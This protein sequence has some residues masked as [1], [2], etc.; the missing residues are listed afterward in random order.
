MTAGFDKPCF[1]F[2][3]IWMHSRSS[4]SESANMQ[5]Y[6]GPRPLAVRTCSASGTKFHDANANGRRDAGEPGLPRWMIW[7]DYDDNGVRDANEP[8]ALTDNE[9]QYVINDIRPPDGTYVLR[10]TLS[11]KK[12]RS[13]AKAASWI[14]SYPNDGTLRGHRLGAGR[15][16]LLR[17]G[18]DQHGDGDRRARPGLR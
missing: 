10:E 4:L 9:G 2:G 12:A 3:S 16:V 11:S 5:D 14:C 15:P 6:L 13:R 17:L 1:S 7:A 8:Y 18:T